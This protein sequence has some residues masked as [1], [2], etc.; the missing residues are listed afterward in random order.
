MSDDGGQERTRHPRAGDRR[1]VVDRVL[2]S[3]EGGT[4][5][6]KRV[7]GDSVEVEAHVFTDGHDA[8]TV[9]LLSR[10]T[11]EVAWTATPMELRWNDE[12]LGSFRVER[13]GE[14]EYTVEAWVDHYRTWA[15]DL[16]KRAEAGQDLEIE[17]QIGSA[18]ARDAAKR[19][20]G[21]DREQIKAIFARIETEDDESARVLA[22]T[23]PQIVEL[24]ALY[25]DR[26]KRLRR[27]PAQ[28][29]VVDPPLAGSGAWYEMFPR[30]A[31]AEPGSHGTFRDV[32]SR[33]PYVQDMGF[34]V[35]YL[36]PI[37]P[38]GDAFRK[39]PNNRTVA[40]PGD[41]G[42]PWA[43]GSAAGGHKAIHPHLG[44]FAEF[45]HLIASAHEHDLEVALDIALQCSPDHPYVKD[46]PEWFK[47]RPDGTIQYAENPPK[48]YEDIYPFNFE[49]EAWRELWTE[50]KSIFEFWI[51][52][53]VTVFRVDNPH[54]KPFAFWD[55]CI[56]ELKQDH[57]ETIFLAE[58]FT[59]PKIMSLLARVGFSQSYTYFAWRQGKDELQ[60]YLEELTQTEMVEYFRPNLWPNTPDILTEQLQV[61]SR[62]MFLSRFVLAA[63][64]GANYGIYGPPFELLE[65]APREPGSEEYLDSEKYEIRHWDLDRSESLA[66]FIGHINRIRRA[67]PAFRNQRSL[68]FH[69]IDNDRLLAYSKHDETAGNT[70]L[71]VVNLDDEHEQS[72]W[73]SL[74]R[75]ALG[76]LPGEPLAL[77]DLLVGT[78]YRWNQEREFVQLDPTS[79]PAHIFHIQTAGG[80]GG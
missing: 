71:V 34:D 18:L 38:I 4:V 48:R 7:V 45:R 46:H 12:W 70:I 68:R 75:D 30:S 47:M 76:V 43:I 53:G 11:G 26:A 1:V 73:L 60:E 35:L 5:P 50:L 24:I 22:A 79:S 16:V 69:P 28:R 66:P 8:L 2:P 6:I 29:V 63:T 51:E 25:P 19:A 42:S 23:D 80:P 65:H 49:T 40:E 39:G 20:S 78:R 58:A 57:P 32:E 21:S 54:T 41:E 67:N 55:W 37:H 44:T 77:E 62:A 15:R 74:D 64:L 9:R 52:Q 10:P 33:L 14:Y 17:F 56:G 3:V 59:R 61:G 13:L 31:A 72:G 36:P 27:T